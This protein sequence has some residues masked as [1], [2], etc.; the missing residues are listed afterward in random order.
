MFFCSK[1]FFTVITKVEIIIELNIINS[2]FIKLIN[3]LLDQP[4]IAVFEINLEYKTYPKIK[5]NVNNI[6][7]K[8]LI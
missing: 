5:P 1:V 6:I 8:T 3:K 7:K 2:P 4:I